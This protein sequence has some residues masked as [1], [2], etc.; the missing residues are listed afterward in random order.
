MTDMIGEK[1]PEKVLTGHVR[2]GAA[3]KGIVRM[4]SHAPV[5]DQKKLPQL[6]VVEG[7]E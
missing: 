2:K 1:R 5:V 7:E 4:T 6:T 3:G